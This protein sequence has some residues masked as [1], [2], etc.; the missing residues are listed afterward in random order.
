MNEYIEIDLQ[1]VERFIHNPDFHYY[2]VN[3]VSDFNSAAFILQTLLN[4]V[5]T[6]KEQLQ[7]QELDF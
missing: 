2:L 7:A 3:N 4:A 5:E 1:E 6:A